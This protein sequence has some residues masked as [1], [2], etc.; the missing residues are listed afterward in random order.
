MKKI[1]SIGVLL[2]F[3]MHN[4]KTLRCFIYPVYFYSYFDKIQFFIYTNIYLECLSL[5]PQLKINKNLNYVHS[6]LGLYYLFLVFGWLFWIY[7]W[8]LVYH[9]TNYIYYS[10][11]VSDV[12]YVVLLSDLIYYYIKN[13]NQVIIPFN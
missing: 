9:E 2:G 13:R 6:F 3:I 5:I 10:L 4:E 1:I 11:I 12:F 8:I 7:F